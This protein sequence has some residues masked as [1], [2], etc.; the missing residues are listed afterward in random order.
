MLS[1]RPDVP[2]LRVTGTAWD[3]EG[4]AIEFARDLHRGDR[5]IFVSETLATMGGASTP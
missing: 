2:A 1:V 3:A 4:R 5:M